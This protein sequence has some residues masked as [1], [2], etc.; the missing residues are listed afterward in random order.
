MSKGSGTGSSKR[1]RGLKGGHAMTTISANEPT[2][3]PSLVCLTNDSYDCDDF[4]CG[5][6]GLKNIGNSC[7]AN[8]TLQCLLNTALP[9]ALTDPKAG[10]IFRRYSS[11]PNIL[12]QGSGS[13]DS[14]DECCT[15]ATET[16]S[17][18]ASQSSTARRR[19]LIKERRRLE[20]QEIQENCRW[21]TAE[22]CRITQEY[23]APD[24]RRLSARNWL[25]GPPEAP[26]V[27][28]GA[29]TRN[30]HRLSRSL[31]PYQ[32]EDAHEFMRALLGTLV[33]NGHNKELSSLFDGLLESAVTCQECCRPSLTR[34]RYMDLSLDIADTHI[35]SL[36]RALEEFTSTEVL[37]GDNSVYCRNCE[38]KQAAT[39]G[40]RLATAP[41][42][43]VC[44]FKRF[45][46]DKYGRMVRLNKKVSFPDRLEISDYMSKV[47]QARPPPYDLVAVLVHQGVNCD[48]GHYLAY[49]KH[50][51]RWFKCNDAKI[52]EVSAD[53]VY[54][55][56]AYILMY[57]VA[58][59]RA[60]HGFEVND[61]AATTGTSSH[62]HLRSRPS[63]PPPVH[64]AP[65]NLC[66][67]SPTMFC[68]MDYDPA[69]FDFCSFAHWGHSRRKS[70]QRRKRTQR[71]RSKKEHSRD[72]LSTLGESTVSSGDTRR[73][74]PRSSSSGNLRGQSEYRR[75]RASSVSTHRTRQPHVTLTELPSSRRQKAVMFA[76]N[77]N[78]DLPPRPRH[79][80]RMLSSDAV[81]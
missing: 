11:N 70:P 12:A 76:A 9:H 49:V 51:G 13:V 1:G 23:L 3:R 50:G 35:T 24:R 6:K 41:S 10:A 57:E 46:F 32:Q 52:V 73:R 40:L 74:F 16:S 8:A 28:P 55:Q 59:M 22:L 19:R 48:C 69:I 37:T 27:D 34:D 71:Q 14:E 5:P 31:R 62:P 26:V 67:V 60:N 33:M 45:A 21:L 2:F 44:H 68:G 72:D 7:Y 29:I 79:Y 30:P 54:A 4:L 25:Y 38:C 15:T 42:I 75:I 53:L 36:S 43:L 81:R 61:F 66:S 77:N 58:E 39:K 78:E 65:D 63:M 20:E 80:R 17:A 64:A 18:M 56:Q 47:N